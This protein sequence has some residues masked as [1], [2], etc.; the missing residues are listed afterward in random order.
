[1]SGGKGFDRP[2][3]QYDAVADSY[4]RLVAPRYAPIAAL[5]HTAIGPVT[6]RSRVVELAAGTGALTRLVAPRVLAQDGDYIAVD[7]SEGMLRQARAVVEQTR[8]QLYPTLSAN[9][10]VR[11]TGRG[12]GSGSGGTI[13]S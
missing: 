13:E 8:S 5:L 7:V 2:A 3:A 10:S 11:R 12:S 4:A 1:M 9:A 6:P